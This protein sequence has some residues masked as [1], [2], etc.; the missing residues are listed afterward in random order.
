MSCNCDLIGPQNHRQVAIIREKDAEIAKLKRAQ[1]TEGGTERERQ[2][3]QTVANLQSQLA[4]REQD[5][6]ELRRKHIEQ[7]EQMAVQRAEVKKQS[8]EDA[9]SVRAM[10]QRQLEIT[11]KYEERCR[12]LSARIS[13]LE[14]GKLSVVEAEAKR[15]RDRNRALAQQV[16]C[17]AGPAGPTDGLYDA[18]YA[19]AQC[20][21]RMGKEEETVSALT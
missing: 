19:M 18:L 21:N 2:L 1:S 7:G 12:V 20:M 16:E 13:E 8:A 17:L 3:E 5:M 4:A 15:L 14:G 10:Q 6:K 11:E 9:F